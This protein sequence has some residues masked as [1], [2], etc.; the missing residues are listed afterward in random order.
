MATNRDA[1]YG[2]GQHTIEVELVSSDTVTAALEATFGSPSYQPPTLPAVALQVYELSRQKDVDVRAI[3]SALET[4]AFLSADVLRMTESGT[5]ARGTPCRSIREAAM[6][7]GVKTL[8]D[9]VMRV[10]LEGR[11]FRSKHFQHSMESLRVHSV[12]VGA[13]ARRVIEETAHSPDLAFLA[14]VLHD[15]GI[16]AG[17]LVFEDWHREGRYPGDELAMPALMQVH[18]QSGEQIATLW[19]LPQ[20]LRW[21][22]GAH[23]SGKT[24]GYAHPIASACVVA[25]AI[26]NELGFGVQLLGGVDSAHPHSLTSALESLALSA[27]TLERLRADASEL[28]S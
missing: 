19:K 2:R 9:H 15:I 11:V 12:A 6:R 21:I 28:L 16:A 27:R 3:C 26:V 18:A 5:F 17:L 13:M 8:R 23:H 4:D 14:G 24:G 22:I 1:G 7:L 20:E 10:A 25:E